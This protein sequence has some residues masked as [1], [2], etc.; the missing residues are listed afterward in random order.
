MKTFAKFSEQQRL[1]IRMTM[2]NKPREEI[3]LKVF[4]LDET[5][6]PTDIQRA[7]TK[8]WR[9]KKHPDYDKEWKAIWR[10]IWGDLTYE[11]MDV[12]REGMRDDQLPWR[13]TQSANMVISYGQKHLLGDESS[14]IKVQV[15]GMPEL[16]TPEDVD[17]GSSQ[18]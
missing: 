4:G 5:A 14:T 12:L 13:R 1:W 9:W 8:M 17:S 15:T 3:L 2:L 10:E 6:S 7:Q 16:G 11:A 18:S